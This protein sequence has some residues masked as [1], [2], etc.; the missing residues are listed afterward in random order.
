MLMMENMPISCR[1]RLAM[2][3]KQACGLSAMLIDTLTCHFNLVVD[4]HL[5]ER[6]RI[7]ECR[8]FGDLQLASL[9]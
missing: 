7:S 5:S 3:R 8:L 4:T 9:A 1:G 2:G 6:C